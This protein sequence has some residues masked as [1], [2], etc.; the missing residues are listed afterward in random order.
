MSKRILSPEEKVAIAAEA[1][2]K[3]PGETITVRDETDDNGNP[4]V[5][6]V[7]ITTKE[8]P[9]GWTPKDGFPGA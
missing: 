9:K 3:Y 8:M 1:R 5:G 2:K 4:V 6:R 7:K